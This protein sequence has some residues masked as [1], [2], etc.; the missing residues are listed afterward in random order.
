LRPDL[1]SARI[2]A[3]GKQVGVQVTPHCLRYTYAT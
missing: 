2:K 3:A 1:M